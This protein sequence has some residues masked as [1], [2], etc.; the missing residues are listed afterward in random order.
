MFF[1]FHAKSTDVSFIGPN[2]VIKT[3]RK[4]L[5]RSNKKAEL[6]LFLVYLNKRKRK[7]GKDESNQ[8]NSSSNL[9]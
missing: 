9:S 4:G 6:K 1:L 8:T 7:D 5:H 2:W 3:N